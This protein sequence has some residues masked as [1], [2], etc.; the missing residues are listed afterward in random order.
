MQLDVYINWGID[1]WV[2]LKSVTSYK[3]DLFTLQVKQVALSQDREAETTC[4]TLAEQPNVFHK[5]H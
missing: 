4:P 2:K 3:S 5:N 1:S